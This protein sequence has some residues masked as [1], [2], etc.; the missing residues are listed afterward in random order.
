MRGVRERFGMTANP[1]GWGVVTVLAASLIGV[2]PCTTMCA[3]LSA[4]DTATKTKKFSPQVVAKADKILEEIG[5][6]RSG[7]TFTSK[8]TAEVTRG[9]SGLARERRKL[10][11]VHQEWK[12]AS[13]QAANIRNAIKQ[14]TIQDGELNIQLARVSGDATANNRVVG[15]I[16]AGRAKI[17]LLQGDEEKS[18]EFV[19]QRRKEL[20]DAESKYAETI[21]AIRKDFNAAR[22]AVD[23]ALKGKNAEIAIQVMHANF[24]T[25][26]DVSAKSILLPLEKRLERVEQ[27]VFSEAIALD[28]EPSGS[29][30][31]D[32][33]VGTT[34]TR[35]VVDSGASLIS[36]P[37]KTAVQLGIQIPIDARTIRLVM[38]D[39]RSIGAKAVTLPRVRVGQFEAENVAAA[40]LDETAIEAEPLLGMS[41]LGNFKFEIDSNE[42]TLKMLRVSTE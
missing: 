22:T 9:L 17:K 23:E 38:A 16:N 8:N 6:K 4:Q 39:G 33:V 41:Y 20:G 5:L 21:L 27:E 11:L 30:Y 7:K 36:L 25:P 1:T 42:K 14:L 18:K 37:M 31:V 2:S 24:E 34:T 28:V 32:V 19:A 29:M 3:T 13:D 35:M 40:V 12:K 10:K 15:L 26:A